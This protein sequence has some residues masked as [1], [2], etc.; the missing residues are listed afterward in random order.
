MKAQKESLQKQFQTI[1]KY[2]KT[3]SKTNMFLYS[4]SK[5]K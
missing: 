3:G 1:R 2:A 5:N 4:N